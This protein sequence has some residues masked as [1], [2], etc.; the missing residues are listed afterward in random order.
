MDLYNNEVHDLVN[1]FSQLTHSMEFSN[2]YQKQRHHV[3]GTS[4]T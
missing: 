4:G 2:A 1:L 3:D